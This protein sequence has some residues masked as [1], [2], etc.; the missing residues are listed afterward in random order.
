MRHTVALVLL[1]AAS[2]TLAPARAQF[3]GYTSFNMAAANAYLSV[4][5]GSAAVRSAQQRLERINERNGGDAGAQQ[6]AR[7]QAQAAPQT[8]FRPGAQRLLVR[9]FAQR[10]SDQPGEVRELTALFDEGFGAFETEARRLNRPNNVAMAFAY[11]VGVCYFVHT[12]EEPT[13]TALLNLQAN[14][15]AAF[16]ASAPF[17]ELSD[18]E[19]QKLYEALVLMA[20]LPLVGATVA[21]EQNDAA[22][23]D[24]YREVAAVALESALGVRPER[25]R[26]TP[27][28]LERR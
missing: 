4:Q 3:S 7:S 25:L 17:R 20:T 6:A 22:L 28:A 14:T 15:D 27:T 24:T 11:L 2:L 1:L 16:G 8:T 13:E 9:S 21:T 23:L 5:L 12:G 10:L 18:G 19:R 26:F